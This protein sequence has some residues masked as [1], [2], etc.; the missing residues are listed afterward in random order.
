M[1]RDRRARLETLLTGDGRQLPNRLKTQIL[2]ALDR[3][4]LLL[5]QIN[6]LGSERDELLAG[7]QAAAP[8]AM[9]MKLEG[10]GSEFG[11]VLWS[12]RLFR[13]FDNR[14]QVAAYAGLAPTPWKS[15]RIDRE[16][17]VSK[18]GDPRLRHTLIDLSWLW[19][20]HQPQSASHSGSRS[21]S[22]A[23]A[24]DCASRQSSPW[25]ASSWSHSGNT[26]PPA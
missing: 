9:L 6:A 11:A 3:L 14:R 23:T 7:D 5:C 2:R 22:G 18:A 13:S 4:E 16:Q 24:P 26:S 21:G 10:V 15:G 25:R 12:E 20:R 8:A 17:G 19:L 1:R